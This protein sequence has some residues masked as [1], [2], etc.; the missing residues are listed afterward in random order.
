MRLR[1]EVDQGPGAVG[2]GTATVIAI[3]T[4]RDIDQEGHTLGLILETES[5]KSTEAREEADLVIEVTE[6]IDT[7]MAGET[8]INQEEEILEIGIGIEKEIIEVKVKKTLVK[9]S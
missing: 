1:K 8:G 9:R 7:I 3:V 2:V 6:V 4:E 5:T